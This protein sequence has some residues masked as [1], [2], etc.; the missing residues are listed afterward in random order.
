MWLSGAMMGPPTL[1]EDLGRYIGLYDKW[2]RYEAESDG[3]LIAYASIHGGTAAAAHRMADLLRDKGATE[4][5]TIDL[6]RADLSAAL[7]EAFRRKHLLL[8]SSSYDGG[9]FTPMYNFLHLLQAKTYRNRRVGLIENGSWAPCAGRVMKEMVTAMKDINLVEPMVTIRSTM[10]ASD[11]PAME[12]LAE[13][14]L[15]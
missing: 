15:S 4:V 1:T 14:M 7:A 13:R 2:S 9:L 10:K 12:T 11:E 8:A 6:C 3:V 5:M